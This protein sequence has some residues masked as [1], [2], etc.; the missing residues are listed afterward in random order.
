MT[1]ASTFCVVVDLQLSVEGSLM[2]SAARFK[3]TIAFGE[4]NDDVMLL[5]LLWDSGMWTARHGSE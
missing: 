4:E 2:L 3:E 1:L 5:P